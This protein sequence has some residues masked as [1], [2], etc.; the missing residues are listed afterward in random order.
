MA[1]NAASLL[2]EVVADVTKAARD[3]DLFGSKVGRSMGTVGT[4]GAKS[5]DM[6]GGVA[7]AAFSAMKVAGTVA[8]GS[9][10]TGLA[11]ATVSGLKFAGSMEQAQIGFES[12]MGSADLAAGLLGELKE[13][14]KATPFEMEG[15]IA[16]ARRLM[17]MGTA[18]ED[19]IPLMTSVGNA[20]A[21]MGGNADMIDAVTR[22]LGQ[23]QA[24][25]K[26]SAEEMLQ[27][28]EAGIP[29]WDMLATKLGV[30]V[31]TA[32]KQVEQGAVSAQTFIAAFMEGT[33]A[34]FGDAMAKQSQSLLGMWSSFKDT[35]QITLGDT[36]GGPLLESLK[37]AF[38][39]MQET[40]TRLLDA[41]GPIVGKIGVLAVGAFQSVLPT[42]EEWGLKIADI[43]GGLVGKVDLSGLGGMFGNLLQLVGPVLEMLAPVV[44][45][46]ASAKDIVGAIFGVIGDVIRAIAPIVQELAAALLPAF[47]ELGRIIADVL[48]DVGPA[49]VDLVGTI[50]E[51]LAQ[52]GPPLVELLGE[53]L[54]V[55]GPVIAAFAEALTP[56]LLELA[57][58]FAELVESV[59][60]LVEPLG[61]LVQAA[62][63]AAAAF[64]GDLLV[65]LAELAVTVAETLLPPLITL[66]EW[67]TPL[68]DELVPIAGIVFG[69]VKAFAVFRGAL[70]AFQAVS[71]MIAMSN[72]LLL[73]ITAIAGAI[74]LIVTHWDTIKEWVGKLWEWLKGVGQK[75]YEVG[76]AIFEGLWKGIKFVFDLWW[77]WYVEI[78]LKI[79]NFIWEG[80]KKLWDVGKDAFT[81]LWDG[82]KWVWDQ[83]WHWFVEIPLQIQQALWG[84]LQRLWNIGHDLIINLWNGIVSVWDWLW[85][86]IVSVGSMIWDTIVGVLANVWQIGADLVRGFWDGLWG[87]LAWLKDK[88]WGFFGGIIDWIREKIFGEHS[89]STVFADI[90]ANLMRGLAVGIEDSAALPADA[91]AAAARGL[92]ADAS[93]SVGAV[94]PLAGVSVAGGDGAGQP[95]VINVHGNLIHEREL[96][97]LVDRALASRKRSVPSLSFETAGI[98]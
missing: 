84:G 77:T 73:A 79:L 1:I 6:L 29:A 92:T 66:I 96:G 42:L 47:A 95:I 7:S 17:A 5:F 36:I 90:G 94:R 41:F 2:V 8:L 93:L 45:L 54:R 85:E 48:A 82:L 49:L 91:L 11:A 13:F 10:A 74:Y 3:L 62:V 18:A 57:P 52:I 69:I 78:P 65:V 12:M 26:V 22:A 67:L 83:L 33:A 71:A 53:I 58:I 16:G 40:A 51:V 50:G 56:V 44:N 87:M 35:V 30:D 70:M 59:I 80:L 34:K 19:V 89:P 63:E 76:K 20:V 61:Q 39:A 68:M 21:A 9:I 4:V 46:L 23:M 81:W 32:M 38:P 75:F 28:A 88:I 24:K 60:P 27:L 86:K 72:P 43:L 97:G 31:P 15:V 64:G 37:A 14:A 98:R 55:L 25:G